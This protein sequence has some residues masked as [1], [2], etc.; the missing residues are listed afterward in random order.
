VKSN[1]EAEF[2]HWSD[3]DVD[4]PVIKEG[5]ELV[6]RYQGIDALKGTFQ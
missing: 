6:I 1:K 5:D 4:F 3:E 2:D